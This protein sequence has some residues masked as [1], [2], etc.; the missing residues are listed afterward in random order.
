MLAM[1]LQ[2]ITLLI[3][4]INHQNIAVPNDDI[5]TSN[6]SGRKRF[7]EYFTRFGN[8]IRNYFRPNCVVP[9]SLLCDQTM[10]C[11][12]KEDLAR[13]YN[14]SP[15]MQNAMIA[16]LNRHSKIKYIRRNDRESLYSSNETSW[17]SLYSFGNISQNEY[18]QTLLSSE[19]CTECFHL[20]QQRAENSPSTSAEYEM[21]GIN[22]LELTV[23]HFIYAHLRHN[24]I[25]PE[26]YRNINDRIVISNDYLWDYGSLFFKESIKLILTFSTF[27]ADN[28]LML[29]HSDIEGITRESMPLMN[30]QICM[31]SQT[32]SET[33]ETNYLYRNEIMIF[34]GNDVEAS[35]LVVKTN[36]EAELREQFQRW[37]I[38]TISNWDNYQKMAFHFPMN[39]SDE[40]NNSESLFNEVFNDVKLVMCDSHVNTTASV[41][42]SHGEAQSGSIYAIVGFANKLR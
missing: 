34:G 9:E 4:A 26:I 6:I 11:L 13:I 25:Y 8:N 2:S 1:K 31:I 17:P 12:D 28:Q 18:L 38:E 3:L 39:D 24:Y 10:Q 19:N 42:S 16:L 35:T 33:S 37:N 20:Y 41:F 22:M 32:S 29:T 30:S 14:V 40:P 5:A 15:F 7:F 27:P 36:N 23:N 21:D